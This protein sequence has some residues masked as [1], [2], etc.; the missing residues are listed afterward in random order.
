ML[1]LDLG[2][3]NRKAHTITIKEAAIWS[4]VWIILSLLFCTGLFIWASHAKALEFLTGYLV[5]KA[6]S[7]DN[8]FV[9]IMIFAYFGVPS[10][11]HHKVLFWGILGALFLR[12]TFIVVGT[13]LLAAFHWVMYLFGIVLLFTA[14]KMFKSEAIEV[15]PEKNIVLKYFKKVFPVTPTFIEGDFFSFKE[16]EMFLTPMFLVLITIETSDIVFAFD[17]IPAIFAITQDP[18]IVYT[19]N[20]CAILGLRALYFLLAGMMR[21]FEYL[22]IGVAVVLICIAIKMLIMDLYKVPIVISLLGVVIILSVS[23]V[24]SIWKEKKWAK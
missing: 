7:V 4:V 9:F 13:M 23:I 21:R 14:I 24:A 11:Y 6:L 8:I 18:F 5:E 2:V 3:F 17:S 1:A 19:S 20:I 15:H 10:K 12:A 16:K 22:Q